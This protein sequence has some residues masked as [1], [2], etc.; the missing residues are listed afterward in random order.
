MKRILLYLSL[1]F[2]V[3]LIACAQNHPIAC[4]ADAK[5]CPDG[6]AVGREGPNCEFSPCPN[7]N[8][9]GEQKNYCTPKQKNAQVCSEIYVPVCGWFD[10]SRIQC[11][12]YPCASTYSNRCI[13]CQNPDVSYWTYGECPK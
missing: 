5:I 10:S 7:E 2:L 11:I 3:I 9:S 8:K 6:T 4:T 1:I 13:A 12:K